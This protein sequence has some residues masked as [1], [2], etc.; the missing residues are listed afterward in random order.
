MESRKW[1]FNLKPTTT[2]SEAAYHIPTVQ[3]I[4]L[5]IGHRTPTS[6]TLERI[7]AEK[8]NRG[9]AGTDNAGQPALPEDKEQGNEKECRVPNPRILS[10]FIHVPTA[11]LPQHMWK[12]EDSLRNQSSSATFW[13]PQIKQ[14]IRPEGK[15]I[16]LPSHF[17]GS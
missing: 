14:I 11:C 15:G 7:T 10:H 1:K 2:N 5:I 8:C 12:S 3:H 17:S 4:F 6:R 9:M 16:C 13:E